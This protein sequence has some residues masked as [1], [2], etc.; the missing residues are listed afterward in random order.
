MAYRR[1]VPAA[2]CAALVVLCLTSCS[3]GPSASQPGTP[4]FYWGAAGETWRSGDYVKTLDDLSHLTA[5]QNEF[6]VRARPWEIVVA[7]GVARGYVDLAD[8]CESAIKKSPARASAIRRQMSAWRAIANSTTL[9]LADTFHKFSAANKQASIPLEF[10]WPPV[11]NA[12]VPAQRDRFATGL[13]VSAADLDALEQAMVQRGVMLAAARATG[14]GE[15]TAK[16]QELFRQPK[17]AVVTETFMVG[18][19]QALYDLSSLYGPKKL[20]APNRHDM[21]IT[22]ATNALKPYPKNKDAAALLAK[23]EKET[24]AKGK[25]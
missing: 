16:A 22:L 10:T 12:A 21:L 8:T 7:T 15:D 6:T 3:S 19:G 11:G 17:P 2:L 9:E 14:A 4:P 13:P 18:M 1:L 24:K 23:I 20:D 5:D 25:K